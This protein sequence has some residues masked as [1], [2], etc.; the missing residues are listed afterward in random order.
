M[1][2]RAQ[3]TEEVLLRIQSLIQELKEPLRK[4][5]KCETCRIDKSRCPVHTGFSSAQDTECPVPF[6]Q[7]GWFSYLSEKY[8]N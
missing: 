4:K 6:F 3:Q 7:T 1:R 2:E 5:S 8:G